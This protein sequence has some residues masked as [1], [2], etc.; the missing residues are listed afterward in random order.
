MEATDAAKHSTHRTPPRQRIVQSKM[1]TLQQLREPGLGQSVKELLWLMPIKVARDKGSTRGR[2]SGGR[3]RGS[4]TPGRAAWHFH[5]NGAVPSCQ[6]RSEF[7]WWPGY[8]KLPHLGAL[9]AQSVGPYLVVPVSPK[10]FLLQ[11]DCN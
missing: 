8:I 9:W 2:G 7:R 5:A 6:V 3:T 4:N 1:L 10:L 11:Q